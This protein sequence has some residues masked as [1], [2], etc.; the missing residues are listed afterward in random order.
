MFDAVNVEELVAK[1]RFDLENEAIN[2]GDGCRVDSA[3]ADIS[4]KIDFRDNFYSVDFV[5]HIHK[6]NAFTMLTSV[7]EF[8]EKNV[9]GLAG[10]FDEHD[11]T[12]DRFLAL[13]SKGV[14]SYLSQH[15]LDFDFV[16]DE[17][18]LGRSI[19]KI[20]REDMEYGEFEFHDLP[21]IGTKAVIEIRYEG[22][23]HYLDF[24]TETV[25]GN[26]YVHIP[27]ENTFL[28]NHHSLYKALEDNYGAG[29][30]HYIATRI[31]SFEEMIGQVKY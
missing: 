9:F 15:E 18:L 8:K 5:G 24:D 11:I 29:M 31:P 12:S 23:P 20:V 16:L 4:A 7:E 17:L 27:Y 1:R 2:N 19:Q 21:K 10:F 26:R 22:K 28:F 3:I 25:N 6:D 30:P 14:E 13:L